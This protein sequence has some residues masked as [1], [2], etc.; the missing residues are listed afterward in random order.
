MKRQMLFAA[1]LLTG[2]LAT[3][4]SHSLPRET[5]GTSTTSVFHSTAQPGADD[6][7]GGHL[8]DPILHPISVRFA[9]FTGPEHGER[10]DY[11]TRFQSALEKYLAGRGVTPGRSEW[12]ITGQVLHVEG[13]DTPFLALVSLYR[14]NRLMACWSGHADSVFHFNDRLSNP[15]LHRNGLAGEIG[16]RLRVALGSLEAQRALHNRL[17]TLH[18]DDMKL[19]LESQEVAGNGVAAAITSGMPVNAR[20]DARLRL[21]LE[22]KG[23]KAVIALAEDRTGR[24]IPLYVPDQEESAFADGTLSFPLNVKAAFNGAESVTVWVVSADRDA[25]RKAAS[26]VGA[27]P[28]ETAK[29][30][31]HDDAH[32]GANA[33]QVISGAPEQAELWQRNP[34]LRDLILGNGG[35][36]HAIRFTLRHSASLKTQFEAAAARNNG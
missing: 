13:P 7:K 19:S 33:I 24:W 8:D 26:G 32:E 3:S 5:Q 14:G 16:D 4:L 29:G 28:P 21:R 27:A 20:S 31:A 17:E 15:A 9:A 1:M 10:T 22:C 2:S 12:S 36:F 35:D 34:M 18:P 23:A 25:F 11:V 6:N 30:E